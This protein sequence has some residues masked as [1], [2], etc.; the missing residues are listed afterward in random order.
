[1]E[2]QENSKNKPEAL[3]YRCLADIKASAISWLWPDRI[4]IGKITLI[5]GNP[6]LG[7]SQL[8]AYMAALVTNN[9]K[10]PVDQT[11]CAQG[12]VIILSAEDEPEDT[13]RP[14]LE[15]CNANLDHIFIIDAILEKNTDLPLRNF[16]L[17]ND[18]TR[19][20]EMLEDLKIKGINIFLIIIDPITAYLGGIDAHKNADVRGL[21]APLNQL[22][23]KHQIAIVA[24]SHLNKNSSNEVLMRVSGSIAFIA[25]ARAAFLVARDNEDENKLL[26]LPL[27]N[28]IGNDKT[29]LS[30]IIEPHEL[31]S[32]IKTSRI[33]WGN[34]VISKSAN[35]IMM[36]HEKNDPHTK[37]EAEEFLSS[38]L[39][40]GRRYVSDIF[41]Q[42]SREMIS[43]K[44]LRNAKNKLGVNHGREGFGLGSKPYWYL[45][46]EKSKINAADYTHH[47]D[48]ENS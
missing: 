16:N 42:A 45:S 35:E 31:P 15:A 9:G 8:T 23:S 27:K 19:L 24:I 39:A 14:R 30:F 22:A 44:V 26:F 32:N 11:V 21:L 33:V 7:K 1:M 3:R 46:T 48:N 43:E 41:K 2:I 34:E 29:G 47:K 20:E 37:R 25:A 40:D 36:Q 10:W 13:I 6:G 28:N 4:A 38:F 17:K 12:G 5:T 18:I